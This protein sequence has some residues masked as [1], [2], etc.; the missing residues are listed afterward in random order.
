MASKINFELRK[1]V[2]GTRV[3]YILIAKIGD[4]KGF[5]PFGRKGDYKM[6]LQKYSSDENLVRSHFQSIDTIPEEWKEI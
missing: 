5:L 2:W 1:D 4:W 6:Y 3:R